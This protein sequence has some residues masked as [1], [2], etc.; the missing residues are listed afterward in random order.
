MQDTTAWIQ[1]I[2]FGVDGLVPAI[3]Q[4]WETGQVL[5]LAYMNEEALRMTLETKQ[6]TYYSRSR[7]QLWIKGESSGHTQQ[8]HSIAYDCDADAILLQV[9]Q[10]GAACHTGEHSCF[11]HPVFDDGEKAPNAQAV[12]DEFATIM[13]R[14]QQPKED[15]YTN[16]LFDNGMDKICKK[17]GE[18]A[19]EV[20]IAC[21]NASAE[22]LVYESADLIY[23]LL[24]AM[25][26]LG[27]TPEDVYK[28]M[29]NRA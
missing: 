17:I 1:N 27:V 16:Y 29:R 21:K 19:T 11:H 8:L 13:A 25:A 26:E 5:M 10:Q 6:A 28:E 12:A 4:E 15:S 7:Q 3:A 22:E 2:A 14:K 18:E 9:T 23:H 20:V 24:V